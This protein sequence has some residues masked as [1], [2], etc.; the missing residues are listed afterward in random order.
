VLLTQVYDLSAEMWSQNDDLDLLKPTN[1][2][3]VLSW[4][5]DVGLAAINSVFL[6]DNMQRFFTKLM[7]SSF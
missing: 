3:F 5:S 4:S 7:K 2:A 6:K 1:V